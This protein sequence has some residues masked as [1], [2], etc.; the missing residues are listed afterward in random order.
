M[1]DYFMVDYFG[2]PNPAAGPNRGADDDNEGD[3][4]TNLEEYIAG[5]VPT[6][7]ASAQRIQLLS[8]GLVMWQSKSNALYELQSSSNLE[9][10]DLVKPL[11]ATNTASTASVGGT[12]NSQIYYRAVK[13]K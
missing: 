2:N 10:W 13:V 5:M 7:S 11:L 3:R 9:E 4:L 12:T 6:N 8:G 1:P